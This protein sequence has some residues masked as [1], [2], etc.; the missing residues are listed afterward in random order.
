MHSIYDQ[1][2]GMAAVGAAVDELHAR[3]LADSRLA[4][5]LDG[6]DRSGQRRQVRAF[7]AGAL[8]AAHAHAGLGMTGRDLDRLAG[9]LASTLRTL[10]VPAARVGEILARIA[11]RRDEVP[12]PVL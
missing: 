3:V 11:P 12:A 6:V 2:G 1:I 7:V 10:G 9:H 8:G 4:P 5:Y